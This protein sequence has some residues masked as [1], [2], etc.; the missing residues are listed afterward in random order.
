MSEAIFTDGVLGEL[1]AERARQTAKHGDQ[2][3]LPDGTGP[4]CILRD[5]PAYE[6]AAR[7]DWLATWAK[8]RTKAASQNE[9][10]DGTITFEHILTEEWAEAIA[11]DDPS[12]LR[13]ELI[14]VAAVAIQWV[15]AID[16]RAPAP[17]QEAS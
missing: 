13:A 11:E 17:C 16:Q 4:L 14:Q 6:N 10:G 2:A 8:H 3:H 5:I 1:R 7:A 12:A 9:G 15:E